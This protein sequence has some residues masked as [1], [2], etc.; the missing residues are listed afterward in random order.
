MVDSCNP[1]WHDKE[2]P[3]LSQLGGI[4]VYK[5]NFRFREEDYR[6]KRKENILEK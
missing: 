5:D 3:T 1:N 2:G 6:G 4:P